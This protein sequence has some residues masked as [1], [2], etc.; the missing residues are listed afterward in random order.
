MLKEAF[1]I[2]E[3]QIELFLGNAF[4]LYEKYGAQNETVDGGMSG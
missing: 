4:Y 2:T 1:K 3:V